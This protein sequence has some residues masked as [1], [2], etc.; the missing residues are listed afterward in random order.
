[1]RLMVV[2]TLATMVFTLGSYV[3]SIENL[4]SA[5]VHGSPLWNLTPGRSL[6]VHAVGAVAFHSVASPGWSVP[7]GWRFVRLSKTLNVT[8]MSFDEVEK[9]GSSFD[10]SPPCAT[11]SSRFCVVWAAACLGVGPSRKASLPLPPRGRSRA[12]GRLGGRGSPP[13]MRP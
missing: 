12:R 3:R 6:K 5:D 2:K 8:R 13:A 9:C 1:M 10:T 7:S 11:I 4:T